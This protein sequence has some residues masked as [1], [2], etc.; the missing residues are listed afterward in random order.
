VDTQA[1]TA[2]TAVPVEPPPTATVVAA[3]TETAAPTAPTT[4][5][6]A[7]TAAPT[8][9]SPTPNPTA[10]T[11]AAT[12]K[13]SATAANTAKP[14]GPTPV[15]PSPTPAGPTPAASGP[16]TLTVVCFPKCEEV[17]LDGAVIASGNVYN[18]EISA[19]NHSLALTAGGKKKSMSISVKPGEAKAIRESL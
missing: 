19:G 11:P 18:K 1:A 10:P 15:G 7:A 14:V 12:T 8:N 6:Q 17:R 9:P 13:P 3:P 4:T 16:G 5:A 2:A